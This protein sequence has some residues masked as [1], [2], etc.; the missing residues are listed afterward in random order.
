MRKQSLTTKPVKALYGGNMK[1]YIISE[2]TIEKMIDAGC[3]SRLSL[4]EKYDVCWVDGRM[5]KKCWLRALGAK[6]VNGEK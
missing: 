4:K 6:E 3:P 5:C 2:K 1:K